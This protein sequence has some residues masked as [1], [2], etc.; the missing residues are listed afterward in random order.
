MFVLRCYLHLDE[1]GTDEVPLLQPIRSIS[2]ERY[3][4]KK[5]GNKRDKVDE[6]QKS[7]VISLNRQDTLRAGG[8]IL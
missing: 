2:D 7:G 5:R 3:K 6:W 8:G 4:A 1:V